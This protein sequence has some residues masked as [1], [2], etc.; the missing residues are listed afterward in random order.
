M[1]PIMEEKV[2]TW[3]GSTYRGKKT[4]RQYIK[5]ILGFSGW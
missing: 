5:N 2:Y 3:G 1:A 4:R